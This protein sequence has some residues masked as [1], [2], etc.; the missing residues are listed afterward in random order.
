MIV[1][2]YYIEHYPLHLTFSRL[3]NLN[4]VSNLG[5]LRYVGYMKKENTPH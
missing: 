2:R 5:K 1:G 4:Y 3:I